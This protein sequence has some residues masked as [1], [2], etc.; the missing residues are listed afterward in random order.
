MSLVSLERLVAT[1]RTRKVSVYIWNTNHGQNKQCCS[2]AFFFLAGDGPVPSSHPARGA[3]PRRRVSPAYHVHDVRPP[4]LLRAK[5][6]HKDT[7]P[8]MP[9]LEPFRPV[10]AQPPSRLQ[11]APRC[12]PLRPATQQVIVSLDTPSNT[13]KNQIL[14]VTAA[15]PPPPL[16]TPPPPPTPP[17]PIPLSPAPPPPPLI[18]AAAASTNDRSHIHMGRGLEKKWD[19][20]IPKKK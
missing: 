9:R 20:H 4:S 12:L 18:D 11:Q 2:S 17:K 15:P 1:K 19:S 16:H 8:V 6:P 5:G 3:K 14:S 13:L 10:C 7:G